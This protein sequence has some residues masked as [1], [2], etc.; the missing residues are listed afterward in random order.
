MYGVV[1][2]VVVDVNV[3]VWPVVGAA[4]EKVKLVDNG[5]GPIDDTMIACEAVTVW[6]GL[7]ESR[8]VSVIVNVPEAV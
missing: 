8:A 4:G 1:P 2:P 6:T 5:L 7:D 3:T